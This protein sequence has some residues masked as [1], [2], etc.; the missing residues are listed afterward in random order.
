MVVGPAGGP[1]GAEAVWMAGEMAAPFEEGLGA[2][3]RGWM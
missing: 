2:F 3:M 1:L